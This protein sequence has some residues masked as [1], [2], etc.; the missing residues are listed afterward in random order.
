MDD[1]SHPL[2]GPGVMFAREELCGE[3]DTLPVEA[4]PWGWV[5]THTCLEE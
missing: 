2:G 1:G 5:H 4:Q 3:A